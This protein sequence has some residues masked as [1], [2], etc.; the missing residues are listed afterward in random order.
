MSVATAD[1]NG[2]G[3]LDLAIACA[4]PA[5]DGTSQES[6]IYWNSPQGFS[7]DRKTSLPGAGLS[8]LADDLNGDGKVD[9]ALA[10]AD[11]VRIYWNTPTGLDVRDPLTVVLAAR[12]SMPGRRIHRTHLSAADTDGDGYRDL[13]AV[14]SDG[15]R[16]VS[17]SARGPQSAQ[18]RTIAIENVVQAAV[19]DFNRDGRPDLAVTRS[20]EN[21]NEYVDSLILWNEGGRFALDR[22]TALPTVFAAGLSAGDLNDDGWPDLVVS[23]AGSGESMSIQ[24]FVYWNH[25]GRFHPGWRTMLDTKG[26]E[27]NCIGDVN[28]DRRPDVVFFNSEGGNLGGYNPNAIYWGDGTRG[29][30]TQRSTLLW[31]VDNVGTVQADFN[32]DGWTD[33]GS[34][35][36]RYTRRQPPTLLGVYL[37]YGGPDGYSESRRVVLPVQHTGSGLRAA[38]LNRDG[39]LDLVV[40][41][42]EPDADERTRTTRGQ[43]RV[44]GQRARLLV[45]PARRDPARRA[46]PRARDCGLQCGRPSRFRW[47]VVW[48]RGRHH[49]RRP[50]RVPR[51]GASDAPAGVDGPR[52]R[53]RRSGSRRDSR[54]DHAGHRAAQ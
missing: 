21:G 16:I 29:Y 45:G 33:L 19:A 30:T 10:R 23:N 53:D 12:E 8:I 39:Y 15:V 27:S 25:A 47:W 11:D 3:W 14:G 44:L 1:W 20:D 7:A 24:S 32:D 35:E 54:P 13:V 41:A 46:R 51:E 42:G 52:R 22:K 40:G 49:L 2:D 18:V 36:M 48:P 4:N 6:A 50:R 28:G 43:R 26:S 9:L 38:D 17:G 31:S 34:L 5:G 37:W